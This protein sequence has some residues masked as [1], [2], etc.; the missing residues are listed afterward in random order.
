MVVV[1]SVHSLE[2]WDSLNLVV[3]C[4]VMNISIGNS[5]FIVS[6]SLEG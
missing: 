2:R 1:Y 6:F 3:Q 4:C 5:W